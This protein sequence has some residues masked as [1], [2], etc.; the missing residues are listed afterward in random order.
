MTEGVLDATVL[1]HPHVLIQ[2]LLG[3]GHPDEPRILHLRSQHH[4]Q[5]SLS[6][7]RGATE[8]HPETPRRYESRDGGYLKISEHTFW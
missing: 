1:I 3:L 2:V 6:A 5:R 8:C 4:L 7:V